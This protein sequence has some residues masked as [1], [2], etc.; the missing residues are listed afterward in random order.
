ME[1]SYVLQ[2]YW[3]T[4]VKLDDADGR[5]RKGEVASP[6]QSKA[7]T[8][9][10][11]TEGFG[12]L[13]G[14]RVNVITIKAIALLPSLRGDE[15]IARRHDIES[16]VRRQTRT[17]GI[18]ESGVLRASGVWSIRYQAA[19]VPVLWY[20]NIISGTVPIFF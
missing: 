6:C 11:K 10:S 1:R 5:R 12:C 8:S 19:T 4:M 20:C 9:S 18:G 3:R 13:L 17:P 16:T 15:E 7:A 14:V 2:R